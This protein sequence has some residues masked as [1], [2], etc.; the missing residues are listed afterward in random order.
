MDAASQL[1]ASEGH[2]GERIRSPR[3]QAIAVRL[4]GQAASP[5]F[6][7]GL[8]GPPLLQPLFGPL[9]TWGEVEVVAVLLMRLCSPPPD[10][11]QL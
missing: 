1:S 4:R 5:D 9:L 2:A 7:Q 10:A 11:R 8:P 3:H 6:L